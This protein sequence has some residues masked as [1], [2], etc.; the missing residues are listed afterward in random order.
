MDK[1]IMQ[2]Y[3]Q[4]DD[5][6]L[7]KFWESG[8][9]IEGVEYPIAET[10]LHT[11]T[12]LGS[13][14]D[15]ILTVPEYIETAAAMGASSVSITDH[16]TMYGVIPLYK[17]CEDYNSKAQ[18]DEKIKCII[19]VEFYVCE[20]LDSEI[21]K[22]HT[23]LHLIAYAKDQIGYKTL[24]RL[25]TTSN[26]HLIKAGGN[27]YP[28]ISKKDLEQYLAPGAEGHGHVILT[29]ACIG[30]VVAGIMF[31]SDT[32]QQTYERLQATITDLNQYKEGLEYQTKRLAE[33][34]DKKAALTQLS[35][36]VYK[37]RIKEL[38][39]N[40]DDA[41][42][43]ELQQEM[44]ESEQAKQE[45]PRYQTMIKEVKKAAKVIKD[46]IE[47][48]L[49]KEDSTDIDDVLVKLNS[50]CEKSKS[51]IITDDVVE[52]AFLK[53]MEY[54]QNLAGKGNW[55]IEMQ[56][57]GLMQEK[58][59][60]HILAKLAHQL[61]IPLVAANDAHMARRD[62][63]EARK[64][65]NALRFDAKWEGPT[66]DEYELYLKTDAQLYQ[67]L[68]KAITPSDAFEAMKNRALITS[69]CNVKLVKEKHY[70]VFK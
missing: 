49:K 44:Q 40:P 41:K 39:K 57:H 56:Y 42:M 14:K 51:E 55:F 7:R 46:N 25:V 58:K 20:D 37:K 64:I 67:W 9:V 27:N 28:C 48:I 2:F 36:K 26:K 60:M 61:D 22:K 19:G 70:P 45:L 52:S 47:K 16:G 4:L 21:K 17:A 33:L 69:A 66:E 68:C 3:R 34:E 63:C 23:R 54:Y 30:G 13:P 35:K 62:M 53:E 50:A 1:S 11:H 32:E 12:D 43:S 24:C 31:A 10:F 8:G 6:T 38:E 59:Y 15:A 5:D 18:D 65:V 29:S